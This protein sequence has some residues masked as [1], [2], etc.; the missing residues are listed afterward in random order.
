MKFH[1]IIPTYNRAKLLPRALDSILNQKNIDNFYIY[2]IDD[3]STDNTREVLKSYLEKYFDKIT[4]KY[5]E[6]WW[7]WSARNIWIEL[8]LKNSRNT[9]N[10]WVIFLDSDDELVNDAFEK[11]QIILSKYSWFLIYLTKTFDEKW[12][13]F[14]SI[15][16]DYE[17]IDY[18]RWLAWIKEPWVF[19]KMELFK[20]YKFP[21]NINGWEVIMRNQ[22]FKDYYPKKIWIFLNNYSIRIYHTETESLC[23]IKKRDKKWLENALKIQEIL[24]SKF[25]NDYKKYQPKKYGEILLIYAQYLCLDWEKIKWIKQFIKWIKYSRNIRF[26]LLFLIA[27]IDYN[28][29][30]NNFLLNKLK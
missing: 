14:S 24:L 2:L 4:Y 9:E 20:N 29:K 27:L 16:K 13:I 23:R 28:M 5:K 18:K 6:N 8:A 25:W 12:N 10:D 21:Q 3:G 26:I 19:C 15:N 7:V 1:I 22:V 30:I 11:I 17:K